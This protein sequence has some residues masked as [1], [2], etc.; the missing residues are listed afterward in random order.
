[1]SEEVR[2]ATV[3][4]YAYFSQTDRYQKRPREELKL[5]SLPSSNKEPLPHGF[6]GDQV[7][8]LN[9]YPCLAFMSHFPLFPAEVMSENLIYTQTEV[10]IR[11]TII[12]YNT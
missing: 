4:R 10:E 9:F 5:S 8:N 12:S 3:R 7:G 6:N 1:M 11:P 2:E